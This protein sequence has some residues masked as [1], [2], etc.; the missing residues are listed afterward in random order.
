MF[1][2]QIIHFIYIS[3]YCSYEVNPLFF[4]FLFFQKIHSSLLTFQRNSFSFYYLLFSCR[5][6]LYFIISSIS[7]AMLIFCYFKSLLI[8]LMLP[9]YIMVYFHNYICIIFSSFQKGGYFTLFPIYH[10]LH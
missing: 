1:S 3:D 6:F 7:L 10:L 4:S 8:C 9:L 2:P 5:Y